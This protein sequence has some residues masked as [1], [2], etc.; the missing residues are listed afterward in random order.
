M[1]TEALIAIQN[2]S[3]KLGKLSR[4]YQSASPSRR[5]ILQ[6]EMQFL[7]NAM[8]EESRSLTRK[9]WVR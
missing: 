1:Q 2:L 8:T 6:I 7:R 9:E 3:I 4:E 5:T